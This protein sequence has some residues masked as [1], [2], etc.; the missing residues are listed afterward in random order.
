MLLK[1]PFFTFSAA[2]F[3]ISASHVTLASDGLSAQKRPEAYQGSESLYQKRQA[4]LTPQLQQGHRK[5]MLPE[6][7][8]KRHDDRLERM[9]KAR[10]AQ[11][12]QQGH[13][14]RT[15]KT[16]Q[17]NQSSTSDAHNKRQDRPKAQLRQGHHKN[18]SSEQRNAHH[19]KRLA[20]VRQAHTSGYGSG[21]HAA[22]QPTPARKG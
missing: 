7:R 22:T 4:R 13:T 20:G 21:S 14:D 10:A 11:K 3:Y 18:M 17:G 15:P 12:T 6:R 19:D 9:A 8:N 16:Y 1:K 5:E 2:I